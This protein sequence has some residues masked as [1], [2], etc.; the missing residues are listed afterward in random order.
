MIYGEL[1]TWREYREGIIVEILCG[2][3]MVEIFSNKYSIVNF[4]HING[5]R[6]VLFDTSTKKVFII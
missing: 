2:N 5:E 4:E 6:Y 3:S 1:I